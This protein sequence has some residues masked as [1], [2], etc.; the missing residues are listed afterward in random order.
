LRGKRLNNADKRI[1]FV[2]L[3]SKASQ[4]GN[5]VAWI[6]ASLMQ[7]ILQA[8]QAAGDD[9]ASAGKRHGADPTIDRCAYDNTY[10]PANS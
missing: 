2:P 7:R 3:N 10:Q 1:A 5:A 8:N 9:M 6:P 4:I